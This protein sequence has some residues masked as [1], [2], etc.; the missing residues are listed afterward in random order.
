MNSNSNLKGTLLIFVHNLD[1]SGANQVILS[2]IQG[3]IATP[4][5]PPTPFSC[6][7]PYHPSSPP[8]L[9]S[10]SLSSSSSWSITGS[11]SS[12]GTVVASTVATAASAAGVI[13]CCPKH[14]P[15]EERLKAAGIAVMIVPAGG[16]SVAIDSIK[17]VT[18]I[19]ANT[20]MA[21]DE[22]VKHKAS[23][24]RDIPIF[25]IIH[26]YWDESLLIENLKMRNIETLTVET[27]RTAF[28]QANRSV[29]VCE[30]QKRLYLGGIFKQA[31]I[32]NSVVILC[33]TPPTPTPPTPPTP[34][35]N[36]RP[37]IFLIIGV[38]CPRKNQ[39]WGVKL[40]KEFK[41]RRPTINAKLI[42]VGARYSRSY[43]MVYID[44]IRDEISM[45]ES[46]DA[47]QSTFYWEDL[48]EIHDLTDDVTT[49]YRSSD[50]LM[51]VSDNEV[52]PLVILEAM[53]HKLPSINTNIAGVPEMIV[54][55]VEGYLVIF[56][57]ITISITITMTIIFP[58]AAVLVI[59]T[60]SVTVLLLRLLIL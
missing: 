21:A 3:G 43:E 48:I 19:I 8:S 36:D 6:L 39:L 51:M 46:D 11:P 45:T 38:I 31:R 56:V 27:V 23:K 24:H 60:V 47:E 28:D 57:I 35:D 30:A 4:P 5:T 1:Q 42:L 12:T 29:F 32:D 49:Y 2:I 16:I 10:S 50:C 59:I 34:L 9:S 18:A 37:F 7:R 44:R 20:I 58:T 25:W 17:D 55:G 26:E 53:S 22:I 41:R 13:V 52:T 40:F 14:G 33:G 54:D 15:F